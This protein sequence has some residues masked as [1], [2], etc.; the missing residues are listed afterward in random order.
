MDTSISFSKVLS[1][2]QLPSTNIHAFQLAHEEKAEEGTIVWT[3]HQ[4]D[5]KGQYGMKWDSEEGKN[6]TFSII[7]KPIIP[8]EYQFYL[9]KAI[10]LGVKDYLDSL[11]VGLVHI[12]WPNDLLI[13]G[14]KVGGILIENSISSGKINYTIAG[15]GLNVNQ[16]KFK[17]YSRKATSLALL[18][19]RELVLGKVLQDL[20]PFIEKRYLML[21]QNKEQLSKDFLAAQYGLG[22]AME[23][24]DSDG[25]FS[26][27]ILS[28]A[29]DGKLQINKNG[30]LKSYSL[31]EIEF[32]A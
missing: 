32:I 9:N 11:S 26:G 2:Q 20:L 12:K 23:F 17:K 5:G 22:K 19:G 8:L 18:K 29:S 1:F 31:K 10:A 21:N 3:K 28:I 4:T 6:L 27:V 24:K 7:M 30:Q 13:N 16:N 15:L 25:L 14:K